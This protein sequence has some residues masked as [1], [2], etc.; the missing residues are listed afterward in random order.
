MGTTPDPVQISILW[1]PVWKRDR[2]DLH[3]D[4]EMRTE[5]AYVDYV[6]LGVRCQ[7]EDIVSWEGNQ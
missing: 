5:N 3:G 7:K 1:T 2:K 4:E 6:Y